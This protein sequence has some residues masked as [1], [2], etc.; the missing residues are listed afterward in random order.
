MGGAVQVNAGKLIERAMLAEDRAEAAEARIADL[1]M[2]IKAALGADPTTAIKALS[3]IG[4]AEQAEDLLRLAL[5]YVHQ[6]SLSTNDFPPGWIAQAE[7]QIKSVDIL[8]RDLGHLIERPDESDAYWTTAVD[9]KGR[10]SAI[11][12]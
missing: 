6:Q 3:W 7:A 11:T 4:R 10:R 8:K 9:A 2:R 1:E 12:E 5:R